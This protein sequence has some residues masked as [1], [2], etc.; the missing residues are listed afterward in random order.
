VLKCAHYI[1][2]PTHCR[3]GV[4]GDVL[5]RRPY[6]AFL[7]FVYRRRRRCCGRRCR[8]CCRSSSSNS[9]SSSSGDDDGEKSL[10]ERDFFFPCF[11]SDVRFVR[12]RHRTRSRLVF[13]LQTDRTHAVPRR[14]HVH[15]YYYYW[16]LST[17]SCIL[18]DAVRLE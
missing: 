4:Y 14:Q 17:L 10:S 7:F 3:R 9:N 15:Y 6:F 13:R 11:F 2:G 8:C 18:R 5:A 1:C 12:S 16:T